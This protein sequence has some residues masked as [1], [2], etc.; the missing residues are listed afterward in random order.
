M[1][2]LL[3]ALW[4]F[5]PAGLANA[6]PVLAC[7]IPGIKRWTTPL[8]F[9][10][11]YKGKRI[12][13]DHKTWLGLISGIVTGAITGGLIYGFYPDSVNYLSIVPFFPILG[14]VLFGILLGFGALAGDA[15]E[16]FFKRQIGVNEGKSW[17][18][19]DQLDY[20]A[21]GLL[22]SLLVTL[23]SAGQYILIII[24]W[25]VMHLL[26]SYVGYLLGLKKDPL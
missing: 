12:F 14:M 4:F 5:L 26:V 20:I 19:Y 13:G 18:P 21:G 24:V 1:S 17:F 11:S 9:G 22:V 3:F 10:K 7:R 6:A 2:D 15:A 16:S 23:L 25:F 8:D